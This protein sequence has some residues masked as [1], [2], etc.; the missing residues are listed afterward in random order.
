MAQW[1]WCE[2]TV[3]AEEGL[4]RKW[5][6]SFLACPQGLH[7]AALSQTALGVGENFHREELLEWAGGLL[8]PPR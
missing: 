6:I 8:P 4:P 1:V 3:P 7:R 5:L 2:G